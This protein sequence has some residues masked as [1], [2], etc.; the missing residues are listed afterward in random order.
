MVE[1]ADLTVRERRLFLK[2]LGGLRRID[3]VVCRIEEY[4]I[5]PLEHWV[6]GGGG[7]PGMV[8]AWRS[9]NVA[10]A[11]A[12]GCRLR[13]HPRADALPAAHLPRVVRRGNQ[14]ALRGNLVARPAGRPP[15]RLD[16]LH[17]YVLLPAF[18]ATDSLPLRC[19]S[20]SPAARSQWIATIEE[21][22]YDFVAQLDITPS[23][24]P[25]ARIPRI[26]QRPVIW[27]AFTLNAAAGPVALPGGLARVGK[28]GTTAA[29]LA[30][31]C[32]I[33]QGRLGIG[34]ATSCPHGRQK[35]A[36]RESPSVATE[37][38]SRIAEQLF[39]VGRYAERIELATRLL[40]VTLRTLSGEAGRLRRNN[41][42]RA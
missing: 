26:R 22:P 5:D 25:V 16:E 11:N 4:G 15:A 33:H 41:L 36:P 18:S 29:V 7:V 42:P 17:R 3:G 2:T 23:E 21:R 28:T 12:P 34:P 24:A 6:R 20:L 39:W 40:R 10:L 14:A 32:G 8:E 35:P 9:G 37:V 19:S 27:R 31:P 38:P 13:L 30:G 1:P